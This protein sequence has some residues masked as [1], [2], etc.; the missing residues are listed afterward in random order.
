MVKSSVRNFIALGIVFTGVFFLTSALFKNYV[1][2]ELAREAAVFQYRLKEEGVVFEADTV[3]DYLDLLPIRLDIIVIDV[4]AKKP[5]YVEI[6]DD[7]FIFS[8]SKT[9]TK[10]IKNIDLNFETGVGKILAADLNE[11]Q[12]NKIFFDNY[13]NLL[14]KAGNNVD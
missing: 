14:R 12:R 3:I 6:S 7:A 1:N 4:E 10:L 13:N 9:L 8:N 11:E 5:V 2:K